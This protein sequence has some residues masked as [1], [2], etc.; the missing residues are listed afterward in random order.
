MLCEDKVIAQQLGENG[1]RYVEQHFDRAVLADRYQ[2]LLLDT[3]E[4]AG[5]RAT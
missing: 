1:R 5:T 2:R 3:I 4:L